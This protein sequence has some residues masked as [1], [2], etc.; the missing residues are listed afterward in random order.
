MNIRE[1][2]DYFKKGTGIQIP[3]NVVE[4]YLSG[5]YDNS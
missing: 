1:L 2:F 3:Q 4:N 5:K